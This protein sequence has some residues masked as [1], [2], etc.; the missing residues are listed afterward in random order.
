LFAD[1]F[2]STQHILTARK[3]WQKVGE[4]QNIRLEENYVSYFNGTTYSD[5]CVLGSISFWLK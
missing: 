1:G 2:A 5:E 4:F 3:P